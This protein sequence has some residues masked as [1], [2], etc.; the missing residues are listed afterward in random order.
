M[1]KLIALLLFLPSAAAGAGWDDVSVRIENRI[2]AVASVGSGTIVAGNG[3]HALVVTC[4]HL[5]RDGRGKLSVERPNHKAYE[6]RLIGIS[7]RADV[8]ALEIADPGVGAIPIAS[9]QPAAAT[10][11]GWGGTRRPWKHRG[12]LVDQADDSVF[13]TFQPLDGDSGGGVFDDSGALAGV[14]WGTDGQEGAAVSLAELRYAL[15]SPLC[16]RYWKQTSTTKAASP[17]FATPLVL[18]AAMTAQFPPNPD[19][20]L[21][22]PSKTTPPVQYQVQPTP[23]ARATP[24]QGFVPAQQYE[25]PPV[26]QA[27]D[28]PVTIR[29]RVVP[30]VES[31]AVAQ[32]QAYAAAPVLPQQAL[33]FG[34]G[35][36][37]GGAYSA[38]GYGLSAGLR[39]RIAVES[40]AAPGVLA[41]Y[42]CGPLGCFVRP[43]R[44]RTKI[45][46]KER[47]GFGPFGR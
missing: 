35:G 33:A 18:A 8:A 40:F 23:Q 13:Y 30:Q 37:Y 4:R 7:R 31:P 21:P 36:C 6:A 14:V 39:S 24:Q 38:G 16:A 47:V 11:I 2:G 45:K 19:K 28:V 22:T 44:S 32:A 1:K 10:L 43:A 25:T 27:Y 3:T 46:I 41:A 17:M 34:G 12:E 42:E 15:A 20:T 26:Q 29:L 9:R 5:F